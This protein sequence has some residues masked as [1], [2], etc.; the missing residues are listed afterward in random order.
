MQR[1]QLGIATGLLLLLVPVLRGQ[2]RAAKPDPAEWVPADTLAYVGVTDMA[3]LW[4]DFRKTTSFQMTQDKEL[5]VAGELDL[6]GPAIRRLK[7]HLGQAVGEDPDELKNP[8]AG[9]LAAYLTVP[10]GGGAKDIEPVLIATVGDAAVMKKYFD[11]VVKKLKETA[12]SYETVSAAGETLHVFAF[13]QEGED[14]PADVNEF[15]GESDDE[16]ANPFADA[17]DELFSRERLPAA[18]SL[19]LTSDRLMVADS[20]DR[21]REIL[22]PRE[23]RDSLAETDDYKALLRELKPVGEVRMLVN[24]P[25]VFDLLKADATPEDEIG[26]T[27][28]VIGAGSL[29][30]V[31]G[32]LRLGAKSYDSKLDLL[33]LTR[34]ERTG[35]AKLLSMENRAVAPPAAVSADTSIYLCL[36]LHPGQLVDEIQRMVAQ[37]DPD[38]AR[39]MKEFLENAPGPDGQPMNVRKDLLD[40]LVGPLTFSMGFTRPYQAES[41]RMLLSLAHRNRDALNQFVA[42]IPGLTPREFRG[43]QLY[44]APFLPGVG[45]VVTGEQV[46]AGTTPAVEAAIAGGASEALADAAAF[47]RAARLAPKDA[48]LVVYM[49]Q[50]KLLEAL[51]ELS[52]SPQALAGNPFLATIIP[53]MGMGDTDSF[54]SA[55]AKK[56]LQYSAQSIVTVTTTTDGVRVTLVGMRPSPE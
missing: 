1:R 56:M 31:V 37:G 23:R 3:A 29:S 15:E 7:K 49:D 21:L 42:R 14:E 51:I 53:A 25:R 24:L 20:S 10:G 2:E 11:S 48:W 45:L 19:C 17:I 50:Y 54:D 28:A 16:P 18:L 30:S 5:K 46:L 9:P 13:E 4:N 34:G 6:Y 41:W 40:H 35:L 12:R 38:A 55:Q 8:F 33:F 43:T 52:K 27:L 36:N 47:K 32:H 26:K 44:G 22:T 39:E